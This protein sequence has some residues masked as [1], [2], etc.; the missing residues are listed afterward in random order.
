MD[1]TSIR[2]ESGRYFSVVFIND[3]SREHLMI[4]QPE[5][6]I[7]GFVVSGQ[8]TERRWLTQAKAEPGNVG[9]VQWAPTVQATRSNY[10]RVHGGEPTLL[11]EQF[12]GPGPLAEDILG[13][14]QGDRFVNKFNRNCKVLTSDR[15]APPAERGRF[16]WI[17]N[18]ELKAKLGEDFAVNT[19]AR[20]VIASGSWHLLADIPGRI[21]L[22]SGRG[23]GV[24]E[25]LHGSY[26]ARCEQRQAEALE[27]LAR[28][29]GTFPIHYKK[30]PLSELTG[31]EVSAAG[32]FDSRGRQVLGYFDCQ[33]PGRE[34]ARWQQPL[35]EDGMVGQHVL[36][37]I[38]REGI[39]LFRAAGYPELGFHGRAEL[40]PTLQSGE[41]RFRLESDALNATLKEAETLFEVRQSDEGGRFYRRIG[42]YRV[43]R[44]H[45]D[46]SVLNPACGCWLTAGDLE[47]LSRRTG[48]LSNEL[49]T[50]LSLLLSAA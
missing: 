30:T 13:S 17:S 9:Y 26:V 16:E 39:A 46:P 15:F 4:D 24:A 1:G 5:I 23:G 43:A 31:H 33:L 42:H 12:T 45:G 32:A 19:D 22:D 21:F 40:G 6:G 18:R 37:Y 29:A 50:L 48:V 8:G 28:T 27:L 49:R 38:V 11:L 35:V 41:A 47:D 14:E 20:S 44:W 36:L 3:G 7:L 25:A 2:H 34:I 10:E